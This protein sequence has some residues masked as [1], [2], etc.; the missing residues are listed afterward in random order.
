MRR[1][2]TLL[3]LPADPLQRLDRGLRQ[4]RRQAPGGLARSVGQG[5]RP[6]QVDGGVA[7]LLPRSEH[8]PVVVVSVQPA[9]TP[10]HKAV[11]RDYFSIITARLLSLDWL[12]LNEQGHRRARFDGSQGSWLQP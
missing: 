12:E 6:T 4:P 9:P 2:P 10:G 8:D 5:P 3:H 11:A 7:D 1:I